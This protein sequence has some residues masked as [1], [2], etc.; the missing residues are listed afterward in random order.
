M[1]LCTLQRVSGEGSSMGIATSWCSRP[2]CFT[3]RWSNHAG[4]FAVLWETLSADKFCSAAVCTHPVKQWGGGANEAPAI[5]C[6]C[7]IFVGS[8]ES[9][10]TGRTHIENKVYILR[11]YSTQGCVCMCGFSV[12]TLFFVFRESWWSSLVCV[13]VCVW[14]LVLWISSRRKSL[15]LWSEDRIQENSVTYC[16]PRSL[17]TL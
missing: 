1:K 17:S 4:S 10:F 11:K 14:A 16:V 5:L 15:V 2:Q 9:S 8:W 3:F 7:Y 13:C 6:C 12:G